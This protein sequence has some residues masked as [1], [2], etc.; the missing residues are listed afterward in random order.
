M[1]AYSAGL[2]FS[3]FEKPGN[4]VSNEITSR[5]KIDKEKAIDFF[6]LASRG[7]DVD[8]A[9][10]ALEHLYYLL[11]KGLGSIEPDVSQLK[12]ILKQEISS[13]NE[14]VLPFYKKGFS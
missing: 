1:V 7:K 10:A 14:N 9:E 12:T 6:I 2:W 3:G 11:T 5:F 13:G 8:Y 4:A